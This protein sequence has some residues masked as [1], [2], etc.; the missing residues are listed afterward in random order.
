MA[1]RFVPITSELLEFLQ[2]ESPTRGPHRRSADGVEGAAR[3]GWD[4]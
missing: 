3:L 1:A 2:A 4:G